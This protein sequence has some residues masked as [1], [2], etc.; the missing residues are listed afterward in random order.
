MKIA[1][2][3][4]GNVAT[5]VAWALKD[6]GHEIC[7][8]YS[9]TQLSA[10][11]L[12]QQLD[13]DFCTSLSQLQQVDLYIYAL[14][15]NALETVIKEVIIHTG[16][17]VHTA[18]SVNINIF[19]NKFENYGVFYPLQ[20]FSKEK[21]VDFKEIPIFVEGNS[22]LATEKL[23]QLAKSISTKAYK[24]NSE[25]RLKLHVAAVFACNFSNYLY[26][27]AFDLLR[28]ENIPF[29]ILHPLILET[30]TKIQTISPL[31]AQTGPARRNDTTTMQKQLEIIDNEEYKKLYTELSLKI[32]ELYKP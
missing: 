8:I 14:T 26:N 32:S 22:E 23:L 29:E 31:E 11:T 7:Q 20:T 15:D 17:H 19:K 4:A 24:A 3:G 12:A 25:Q 2:L 6:A 18:G 5:H 1:I 13:T 21:E 27:I 30:A 16:I 28:N 10:E 9:R